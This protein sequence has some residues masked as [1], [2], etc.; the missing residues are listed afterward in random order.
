MRPATARPTL[1]SVRRLPGPAPYATRSRRSIR[2][3]GWTV[4][5]CK[6]TSTWARRICGSTTWRARR[7][8]SGGAVEFFPDS[9]EANI[10]LT[11]IFYKNGTFGSSYLQA[12]T[13]LSKAETDEEKALALYWRALSHEGRESWGDAIKDWNLLLGMPSSVM[14]PEM[15]TE[16][17][18]HLR[19]IATPTRTPVAPRV[20]ATPTSTDTRPGSTA[21]RPPRPHRNQAP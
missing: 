10:G 5:R 13:S 14:T 11:E 1:C 21:T 4:R 17:R 8:T 6:P 19:N 20:T 3:C 15:R 9:F 7:S 2:P 18:E 12:E 16:A